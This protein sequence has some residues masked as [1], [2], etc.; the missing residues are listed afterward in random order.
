[1]AETIVAHQ[2]DLRQI[3]L[4]VQEHHERLRLWVS[5]ADIVLEHFGSIGSEHEAGEEHADKGVAYSMSSAGYTI[6]HES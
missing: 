2:H 4:V 1:M 6:I 5:E 3:R